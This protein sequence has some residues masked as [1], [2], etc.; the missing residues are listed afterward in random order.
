MRAR[1]AALI[2]AALALLSL[3]A[4]H[5]DPSGTTLPQDVITLLSADPLPERIVDPTG[6]YALLVHKHRLL[7]E[8]ALTEPTVEVAGVRLNPRTNARHAAIPY[9]GLTLVELGTGR[10]QRLEVPPNLAIGFPQWAPDGTQ[11]AFTVT[12]DR[13]VE[14]WTGSPE[15]P[16]PVRRVLG[17]VLNGAQ[18]SPC[19]F[20]PDSRSL[21]CQL[22]ARK[23]E[24][25]KAPS[26]ALRLLTQTVKP[27][28]Q[29][30]D[31]AAEYFLRA[32]LAL[33][34]A[35]GA[36][37]PRAIGGPAVLDAVDPSPSGEY[38]LVTR[39]VPPY[40]GPSVLDTGGRTLEVWDT[41]GRL[42]HSLGP[43]NAAGP[44]ALHWQP[45]AP[46]TLTWVER[47]GDQDRLVTQAAPF[48]TPPQLLFSSEQRF[49]GL[50]WLE[51]SELALFDEY[52]V[53]E[54]F[55]RIW[56]LDASQFPRPPELVGSRGG[57]EGPLPGFGWPSLTT[58]RAG[59]QVVRFH[60]GYLYVVGRRADPAGS[61]AYLDRVRLDTL[62]AE[63]LWQSD[64]G[65]RE[66]IL[67]LLAADGSAVLTQIEDVTEP[68]N[69]VVRNL[70]AGTARAITHHR[71]PVPAMTEVA[72]IP[73]RYRRRDGVEMSSLLYLPKRAAGDPPLPMVVWAYPREYREGSVPTPARNRHFADVDRA[74]QLYLLLRGYAVLDDVSMPIVGNGNNA[75]DTFVP[76]VIANAEAAI[77]AAAAT[78][79]V[80]PNRVA[81]AG[82]SYGAFMVA[83]LLAHTELFRAGV[84]LSGA[85]NRTLT[86][87][88]FQTERRTLWE[89]PDAYLAMS[90][91]LYTHQI[92]APMLLVH[93]LLDD[94]AGTLPM[95]SQYMYEAIRRNGGSA[96]LLLLPNEGHSYR[97]RESVLRTATAMLRLFDEHLRGPAETAPGLNFAQAPAVPAAP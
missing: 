2:V 38:L 37:R 47:R 93:G 11:F 36:G 55:T 50:R 87:F 49:S 57:R 56:L 31:V 23:H 16:H 1:A 21:L 86:P 15:P 32:Q 41:D 39:R 24:P 82:H 27:P 29:S 42:M 12:V 13:G 51:D 46:A 76:Q 95:Q 72:R 30:D 70:G 77:E 96:E 6:R 75:N 4:A 80:D 52:D 83:N 60:D 35:S 62:A 85:Y 91:I 9:Y 66:E 14:L 74:L 88:G 67:D 94:N 44:R 69:Y 40:S 43:D 28:G 78:G 26:A 22:V 73:L 71:H 90:P 58:D 53:T 10:T 5:A 65:G 81:V 79:A 3:A 63:R 68:P 20:M 92:T 17:P 59:K 18:G 64:A 34:D 45:S 7:S 48:R 25:P 19:S 54:R 97:G 84:G 89:A 8:R 61:R 33:V